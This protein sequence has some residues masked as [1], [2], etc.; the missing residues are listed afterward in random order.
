M[1]YNYSKG[2]TVQGDIAGAD[3]S[4]RDT[5]INFGEDSIALETGG[6]A[7][8]SIGNVLTSISTPMSMSADSAGDLMILGLKNG[9]ANATTGSVGISCSL[10]NDGAVSLESSRIITKKRVA[11]F[12]NG[13][14]PK[15]IWSFG[16]TMLVL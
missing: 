3:D 14:T 4:N 5:K 13:G 9:N 10:V 11:S 7:R 15:Q 2:E 8:I 12:V 16:S 1:G 6:N